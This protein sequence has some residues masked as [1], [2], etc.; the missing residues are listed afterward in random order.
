MHQIK[1]H[2]L[3]R[4]SYNVPIT[5]C[6]GV[7]RDPTTLEYMLVIWEMNKDLRTYIKED[8]SS[9]TWKDVNY[10]FLCITS[11]L[12]YLHKDNLAHQD[13]HPGNILQGN[14]GTWCIADFGI[15]GPANQSSSSIYGNLP[16]M[17]PE[18]I[19]G[20]Q[21]STAADI[22]SFGML[23]YYVVIGR[24]PFVE[25]KN[26]I[27]LAL[28]IC[29]GI[30]PPITNNIPDQYKELMQQCWDADISKRPN[31]EQLF[32]YFYHESRKTVQ[33]SDYGTELVT[34]IH[35]AVYEEDDIKQSSIYEFN[36]LPIPR[37]A[38]LGKCIYNTF[39]FQYT[40]FH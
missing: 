26:D 17:A 31:A 35:V 7:T 39:D 33:T 32:N 21:Y 16:Y 5:G 9:L 25:Q 34:Q 28:D 11:C 8:Y 36:G 22:Y 27:H 29:N 3:L 1:Q 38:T 40:E 14:S 12:L 13:L 18:V 4:T 37:N 23:M 2:L 6:Y 19:R 24:H 20:A 30:R 15:C 10:L